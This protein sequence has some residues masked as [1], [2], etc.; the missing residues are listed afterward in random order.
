MPAVTAPAWAWRR[1]ASDSTPRTRLSRAR[2]TTTPP[3]VGDAPDA[4]PVPAPRGTIGMRCTAQTLTTPAT[5]SVDPGKTTASG[6]WRSP[7]APHA[8]YAYAAR[9]AGRL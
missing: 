5:S 1:I 3:R 6:R 4:Y 8:S 7:E 9:S 2:L